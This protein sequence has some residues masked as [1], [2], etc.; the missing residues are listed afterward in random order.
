MFDVGDPDSLPVPLVGQPALDQLLKEWKILWQGSDSAGNQTRPAAWRTSMQLPPFTAANQLVTKYHVRAH[1]AG[2]DKEI[3]AYDGFV[4]PGRRP[5]RLLRSPKGAGELSTLRA[6]VVQRHQVR[7]TEQVSKFKFWS[8][9][10][11]LEID[12]VKKQ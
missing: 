6:H 10:Q 2:A 8:P 1:A 9:T 7:F 5:L 12:A 3:F 4:K 11:V